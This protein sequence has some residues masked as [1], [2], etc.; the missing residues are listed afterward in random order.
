MSMPTLDYLEAVEH[1]P[2]SGILILPHV[3]AEQ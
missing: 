3:T 1:L 2:T